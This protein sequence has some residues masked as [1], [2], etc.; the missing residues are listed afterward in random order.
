MAKDFFNVYKHLR[1]YVTEGIWLC[2]TER[3]SFVW[4]EPRFVVCPRVVV[5]FAC[6]GMPNRIAKPKIP[7]CGV[8]IFDL[9]D[10]L[11]PAVNAGY[12]TSLRSAA[13]WSLLTVCPS[14]SSSVKFL[15][16]HNQVRQIFDTCAGRYL[17]ELPK[18]RKTT[19]SGIVRLGSGNAVRR[20]PY[21]SEKDVGIQ[22]FQKRRKH[23]RYCLATRG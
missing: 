21:V 6:E 3:R 2:R 23:S 14:H 5:A 20:P 16:G 11:A 1:N 19:T 12:F 18:G 13:R 15:R 4:M 8:S 9:G 7:Y 17:D 22:S 10:S